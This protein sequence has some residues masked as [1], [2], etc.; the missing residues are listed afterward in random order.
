MKIEYAKIVKDNE[1][2]FYVDILWDKRGNGMSMY[3]IKKL[4]NR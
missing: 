3:H 1:G 2:K 4:V